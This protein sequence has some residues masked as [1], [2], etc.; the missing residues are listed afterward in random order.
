MKGEYA[1][2]RQWSEQHVPELQRILEDVMRRNVKINIKQASFTL[3]TKRATDLISGTI[4]PIA[5]AARLR[6]PGV[7]WARNF[8]SPTHWGLQFTIRSRRDSGIETELAKIKNGFADW[9]L[10]GHVE[11]AADD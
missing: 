5:F 9:F 6:R 3:D 11:D 8:N 10:Y 2:D 7:F 4:G 1:T